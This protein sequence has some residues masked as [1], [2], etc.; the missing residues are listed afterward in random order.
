VPSGSFLPPALIYKGESHDLQDTWIED[1]GDE[2]AYFA[3]S[4]NGW[5]CDDLG[6]QWLLKVFERH[7]RIKA[8]RGKRLLIFDGHS[9]HVNLKFLD[10]ADQ[11]RIIVHIMPP[12]STHRLQPL[13]VGLFSPLATAY[14]KAL[15]NMMHKSLGMVYVTKRLF[16]SLFKESWELAFIE[17]NVLRSF[18]KPGIFPYNPDKILHIL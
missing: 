7:T 10:A 2:A 4:D 17:K 14:S 5:S 11:L 15:N 16:W 8:G 12:H 13:D 18:E 1:L 9:S 3:A 6:L